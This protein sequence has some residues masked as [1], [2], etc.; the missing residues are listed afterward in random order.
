MFVVPLVR[1][2]GWFSTTKSAQIR[3]SHHL[4]PFVRCNW[5]RRGRGINFSHPVSENRTDACFTA[6]FISPSLKTLS[7]S[8]PVARNELS[9]SRSQQWQST[10]VSLSPNTGTKRCQR[11]VDSQR[12]SGQSRYFNY[13]RH[14]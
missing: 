1:H 3:F 6:F 14:Y 10:S 8:S 5:R 13:Y 7:P 9:P 2:Q 11:K 12:C 4:R